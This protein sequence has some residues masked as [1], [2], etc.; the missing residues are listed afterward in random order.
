MR[1]ALST[2]LV[3]YNSAPHLR[4]CL[5]HLRLAVQEWGGPAE[6]LVV[7]NAS[8][9]GTAELAAAERDVR[10]VRRPFNLGFAA[11]VNAGLRLARGRHALLLNPDCFLQRGLDELIRFLEERPEAAAAGPCILDEAGL[12]TLSCGRFPSLWTELCENFWLRARFPRSPRL[13]GYLYG[14][15]DRSEDR[16]VDWLTGACLLLRTSA[17]E[18]A[19]PLDEDYF[20]YTEEV[21]LQWRLAQAGY[22][23][24]YLAGPRAVH[25]GGR[26][27]QTHGG[28]ALLEGR[29]HVEFVRSL[30]LFFRKHRG[31][32][33][34]R[35]HGR[36]LAFAYL[37]RLGRCL[38]RGLRPTAR[39]A[40]LARARLFVRVLRGLVAGFPPPLR[41]R[42]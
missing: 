8:E 2:I 14:D 23:S 12:P 16:R 1:P 10:L 3:T 24:W 15:W 29:M 32:A 40:S 18:E 13:A 30:T 6:T 28:G 37:L 41:L 33:Q 22:E 34:A 35:W 11:G 4:R 31:P 5:D 7:D 19:G 39:E 25:L 26:S 27:A 38:G 9:D 17:L 20:L 21:D 42:A 36:M